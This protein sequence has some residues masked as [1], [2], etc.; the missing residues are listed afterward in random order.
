MKRSWRISYNELELETQIG[1]GA[2]GVVFRGKFRG[3][4]VAI[5]R[6]PREK[7]TKSN[8]QNFRNEIRLMADL[9]H[10]QVMQ[11]IGACW[12]ELSIRRTSPAP[13]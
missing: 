3:T 7:M 8:L 12:G 10:P 1:T 6:L 9:R 13:K 11:F 2:K 4:P 5:K